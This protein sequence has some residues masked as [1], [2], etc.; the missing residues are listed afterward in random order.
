M[1]YVQ[2]LVIL[3]ENKTHNVL[4]LKKPLRLTTA[5]SP[6]DHEKKKKNLITIDL[7]KPSLLLQ[8]GRIGRTPP[9]LNLSCVSEGFKSLDWDDLRELIKCKS[10][11]WIGQSP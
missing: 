6:K 11:L 1:V 5:D 7:A 4:N 10:L 3:S 8:Q 9:W 2:V